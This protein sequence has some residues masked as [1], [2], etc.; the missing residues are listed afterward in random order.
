[1]YSPARGF[2]QG[3]EQSFGSTISRLCG[4]PHYE[5]CACILEQ[6]HIYCTDRTRVALGCCRTLSTM[7]IRLLD[8]LVVLGVSEQKLKRTSSACFS[9]VRNNEG[10]VRISVAAEQ[11]SMNSKSGLLHSLK[12]S[13]WYIW[14][15]SVQFCLHASISVMLCIVGVW[16]LL[17]IVRAFAVRFLARSKTPKR[18]TLGMG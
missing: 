18:S 8:F 2:W 7:L 16:L 9:V 11:A 15:P 6:Q 13:S 5:N 17:W 1:M 14:T 12:S 4:D 10:T 3:A